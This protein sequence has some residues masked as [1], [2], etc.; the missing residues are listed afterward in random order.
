MSGWQ[1]SRSFPGDKPPMVVRY[2]R[3]RARLR[4]AAPFRARST[5]HTVAVRDGCT[6][7]PLAA[8][9]GSGRREPFSKAAFRAMA[10][11]GSST[12]IRRTDPYRRLRY[13]M[14]WKMRGRRACRQAGLIMAPYHDSGAH[15]F[16][17]RDQ[18]L[19]R[20]RKPRGQAP[21]LNDHT[22]PRSPRSSRAARSRRFMGSCPGGSSISAN[23]FSRRFAS[24]SPSRR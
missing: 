2:P 14:A 15:I 6:N 3:F 8:P 17:E 21:R 20:E 12:W 10:C 22:A 9:Q 19:S 5:S 4:D 7:I 18:R 1:S 11:F 24:S 16:P 13:W 23:G